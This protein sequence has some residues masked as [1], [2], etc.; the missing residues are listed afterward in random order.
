MMIVFFFLW[1]T[2]TFDRKK[3]KKKEKTPQ[4][5]PQ[6]TNYKKNTNKPKT[7]TTNM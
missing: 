5:K 3:K 6:T 4:H 2:G 1:L 7:Q